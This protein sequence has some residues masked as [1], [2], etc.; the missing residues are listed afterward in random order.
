MKRIIIYTE[1]NFYL[2][3]GN[4]YRMLELA[5]SILEKVDNSQITFLTSS[6]DYVLQL[7]KNNDFNVY[8]TRT[9]L[10]DDFLIKQDFNVLIVDKLNIS[11]SLV[12][13]IKTNKEIP[14]KIVIFGNLS[15]ANHFADLVVNAIIGTNFKNKDYVDSFG[16]MYLT[17]PKYLTLRNEFV[18]GS[19]IFKGNCE[20]ILLLFGGTDQANYSC[21][22][23]REL[24]KSSFQYNITLVL[25]K[26]YQ[27]YNELENI[28][29]EAKFVRVLKD[30]SNVYEVMMANDFLVTSPGTA[31]FE[32]L[33]IGL[34]CLA[35]YQND[36]QKEI[37]SD[38]FTTKSYE[39]L[40]SVS[41]Y[42]ADVYSNFSNYK[43][44]LDE[45]EIGNG[46]HDIINQIIELI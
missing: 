11:A 33:Y 30:I 15:A 28:L 21:I 25:G 20:N 3:L 23:L 7:I 35:L 5:K 38:F 24:L 6:E 31:L 4:V 1:G 34:P 36:S 8:Q 16:T 14:P 39:E 29:S 17:G 12:Q 19:H 13:K 37:F 27:F 9:E 43:K 41:C 42:I 46:K 2:G 32:G 44:E 10:L 26:G 22:V 18:Q 40:G 45:L